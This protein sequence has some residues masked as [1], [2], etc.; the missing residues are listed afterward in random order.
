LERQNAHTAF[1]YEV[2]AKENQHLGITLPAGHDHQF[3]AVSLALQEQEYDAADYLLCPSEFVK[4]TFLDRGFASGKLV[5]HQYGFDEAIFSPLA[6]RR[7]DRTGLSMLYA[8]V[9]EPR[10]GLHHALK[11]WLAS[12]ASDRGSFLI[13]GEFVRGYREALAS[14]LAHPSV[15]VLGQRDDLPALMRESDVFVLS[16]VEE[17]SALVTYEARGSGCVLLVSEATGAI[18]RDGQDSLVHRAGDAGALSHHITMLDQDRGLLAR[19]RQASLA[20]IDQLTWSAAGSR[21]AGIYREVASKS[22]FPEPSVAP[23]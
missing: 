18:C 16:S 23:A 5:R 15:Q 7:Q 6:D 2:V 10:K 3:N 22:G 13:C 17:G 20:T 14:M 11:A 1:A 12:T 4:E 8:G 9:C 19:L 21:L